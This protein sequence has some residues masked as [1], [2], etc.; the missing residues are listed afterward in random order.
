[1]KKLIIAVTLL[2]VSISAYAACSTHQFWVNG[3]LTIC[4]TCC[5]NG[6]CTTNCF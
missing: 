1:M 2:T 3:R 5:N 4:T 6:N